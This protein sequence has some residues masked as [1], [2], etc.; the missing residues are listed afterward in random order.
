MSLALPILLENFNRTTETWL[1][2]LDQY[3]MAQL[4]RQP[5]PRS[6]SMGQ[7][8]VH[9]VGETEYYI[10]QM[11][12]AR[13]GV[14]LATGVKTP[15]GESMFAHHAFPDLALDSPTNAN[16]PQP[17]SKEQLYQGLLHN[18]DRVNAIYSQFDPE[19]L[20]GKTRHPGLGYFSSLDWLQFADMHMRHHLRQKARIDAAL[21]I[22]PTGS[23]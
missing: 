20:Q 9:I 23:L 21:A 1:F 2:S 6:W 8:Y 7:V 4:L 13:H 19:Q 12:E 22:P 15:E 18:R 11:E 14:L 17:A 10:S 16:M 3:T 5:I